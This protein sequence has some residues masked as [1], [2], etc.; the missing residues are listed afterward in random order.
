MDLVHRRARRRRG[1]AEGAGTSSIGTRTE[2]RLW[3]RA[4]EPC[5]PPKLARIACSVDRGPAAQRPARSGCCPTDNVPTVSYY[6]FFQVGSRNERPGITGISHLFE[7]MMF[8]GAKKYGPKEFD[9][10][11]ESQRRQ[12]Q[13]VHLQRHDRVLRGLHLRGAGDGARPRV[14]TACARCA[15]TPQMLDERARGGEG[16][17]PPPRRQRDRRHAG[18]GAG[19]ARLQ[20]P[21]VPLAGDRLDGGHRGHHA[22]RTAWSTSAPTT[23]PTTPRSTS[24]GDF[25]PKQALA[26]IKQLLRRHPARAR[27]AAPV[28]DAEPEQKGE[29][30]AEVRH[31]AQAPV[32]DDR[33]PR[34]RGAATRTRSCWT[35][36]STRSSV[37]EG[38]RLMQRAGLRAGGWRVACR[39][40]W[41][42]RI[43]PGP[44]VVYLE[45]KPGRGPARGRGRALR[46]A[47]AGR[48]ARASTDRELQKAKNNLAA[49][50][51]RE[52]ATNNGRAPRAGA[53]RGA[54]GRWRERAA[55]WPSAT[56][57]VTAEQVQ[58]A[59]RSTSTPSAARW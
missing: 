5:E 15:I 45:L 31:P 23:R 10:V 42:W 20:G 14:A 58:A 1:V 6:T 7:H 51:L 25:D 4:D 12:L 48:R 46:G 40:D 44:F 13:R 49:H 35:C 50:L 33:L 22:A 2:S 16:G 24:S 38:S 27:G 9:R 36:C 52:L 3:S 54:A 8:N 57:R 18:R 30:R 59:A 11:L 32:A 34:P 47:G 29:R 37:G 19:H 53:L 28:L 56:R 43:D 26:L 55:R 39:V 17:A 41:S 21:P